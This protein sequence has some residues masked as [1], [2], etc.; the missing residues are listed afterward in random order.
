MPIMTTALESTAKLPA[1]GAR[2]TILVVEDE[3]DLAEM[4]RFNLAREGYTCEVAGAGDEVM[5]RV[6][7]RRPDLIVLDRMLP[8]V[9]GDEV[10]AGLARDQ[11]TAGIPVLMLTA[12]AEEADQLVGFALG[13][14]DYV[15]KPFSMKVLLARI[16]AILR[17][18]EAK[19]ACDGQHDD[20]LTAGPL[21]VCFSRHEALADGEPI[22]LTVTEF[23]ILAALMRAGGR[24]LSRAQLL[25]TAFGAGIVVTDRTVD[26]H[27]T[28]LR[29][30]L[31][32]HAAWVR[33]VRGVGYA[34]RQPGR[35]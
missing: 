17:R 11:A 12:K 21:T 1:G 27:I 28:A 7:R 4:L 33:T 34:F 18:A 24:V 19:S 14:A 6:A 20:R 8:G 23:R 26:V 31:A 22:A 5:A 10:L 3:M 15:P 35:D 25:D 2:G 13:A 16:A 30:K 32:K 9:S 29:K